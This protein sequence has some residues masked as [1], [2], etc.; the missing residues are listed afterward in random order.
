MY[1]SASKIAPAG[2]IGHVSRLRGRNKKTKETLMSTRGRGSHPLLEGSEV[3]WHSRRQRKR[4]PS[5]QMR[6]WAELAAQSSREQASSDDAPA[7]LERVIGNGASGRESERGRGTFLLL[8]FVTEPKSNEV[9][10]P[11]FFFFSPP[12]LSKTS[13]CGLS[14]PLSHARARAKIETKK[15]RAAPLYYLILLFCRVFLLALFPFFFFFPLLGRQLFAAALALYCVKIEKSR[16]KKPPSS[17]LVPARLVEHVGRHG[18]DLLRGE[19]SPPG[20]H[21]S[22]PVGDLF[23]G[24]GGGMLKKERR[25]TGGGG[26]RQKT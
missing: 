2:A 22:L 3:D 4:K 14:L 12:C 9:T 18:V 25:E 26:V 15:D 8:S 11:F 19:L 5:S 7:N 23:G 1:F 13:P 24:E 21:G 16:K 17:P 20:G 6:T 10:K